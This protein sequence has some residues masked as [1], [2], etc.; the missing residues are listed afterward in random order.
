M[1]LLSYINDSDGYL[2][3]PSDN[4]GC[5]YKFREHTGIDMSNVLSWINVLKH[6]LKEKIF[7][8]NDAFPLITWY[9]SLVAGALN[10]DYSQL[11]K[12]LASQFK[13][14]GVLLV[15]KDDDNRVLFIQRDNKPTIANPGVWYP[16]TETIELEHPNQTA[17]RCGIEELGVRLTPQFIKKDTLVA[18]HPRFIYTARVPLGETIRLGEGQGYRYFRQDELEK[19]PI[20]PRSLGFLQELFSL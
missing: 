17:V 14:P 16:P 1:T 5:F 2:A 18:G 20:P 13:R 9:E 3:N 11:E 4:E 10:Q 8:P 6:N 19:F 15:V 7:S 12:Y